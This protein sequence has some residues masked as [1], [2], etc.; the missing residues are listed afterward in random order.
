MNPTTGLGYK[1]KSTD[2]CENKTGDLFIQC[3]ENITFSVKDIVQFYIM[4]KYNDSID[5][6]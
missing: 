2:L 4:G 5:E 6:Y 1:V 3:F